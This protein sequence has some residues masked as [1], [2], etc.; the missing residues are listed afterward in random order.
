MIL[1]TNWNQ[2][3]VA[4]NIQKYLYIAE[5]YGNIYK[6]L[7]AKIDEKNNHRE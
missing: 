4:Q 2:S 7:I 5:L 6:Q 1:Y 3:Q